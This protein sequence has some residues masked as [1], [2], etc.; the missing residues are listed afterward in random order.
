LTL[1]RLRLLTILS[2]S[3]GAAVG[4]PATGALVFADA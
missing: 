2:V 3:I 4:Y 1:N